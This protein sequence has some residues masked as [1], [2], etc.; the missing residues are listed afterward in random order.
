MDRDDSSK[1]AQ[2]PDENSLGEKN[3][4]E[5]NVRNDVTTREIVDDW[6]REQFGFGV[7]HLEEQYGDRATTASP[8]ADCTSRQIQAVRP[9]EVTAGVRVR[10]VDVDEQHEDMPFMVELHQHFPAEDNRKGDTVA[11]HGE[12]AVLQTIASLADVVTGRFEEVP[13]DV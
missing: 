11:I 9:N 2:T 5:G 7:T 12:H 8:F 4:E 3:L 10:R 1:K 13:W 6:L